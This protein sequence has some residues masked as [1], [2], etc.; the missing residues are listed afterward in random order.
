MT[1]MVGRDWASA[2]PHMTTAQT[3][4]AAM[5]LRDKCSIW[6]HQPQ[7]KH[8]A[9]VFDRSVPGAYPLPFSEH[10]NAVLPD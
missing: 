7:R 6:E 3:K 1:Y 4:A 9:L 10:L 5:K 8:W 2:K